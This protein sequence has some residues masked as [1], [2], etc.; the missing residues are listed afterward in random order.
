MLLQAYQRAG[1]D[2]ADVQLIEGQGIGTG[3]GDSAELAALAQLRRD[4]RDEGTVAA[5]G[6][7][8]ACIGYARAAAGIAS[9]VKAAVAMA[10]G[11]IPPGP[12]GMGGPGGPRPH[13]L[14][15]SGEALLRLPAR[16]EPWPDG[17]PGPSGGLGSDSGLTARAAACGGV[18]AVPIPA[19]LPPGSTDQKGRPGAALTEALAALFTAGALTDLT[20]FLPAASAGE[21]RRARQGVPEAGGKCPGAH[22]PAGRYRGCAPRRK[23]ALPGRPPPGRSAAAERETRPVR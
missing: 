15:A 19:A 13:P 1:V 18:P 2:P 4:G 10:A 9:L 22:W 14:I 20:P 17:A 16:P 7:I 6:A 23:P 12:G 5:L 11:T 21:E 8:S 3:A